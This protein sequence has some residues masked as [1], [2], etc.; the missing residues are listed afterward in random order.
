MC[1]Q[2]ISMIIR[3]KVAQLDARPAEAKVD[4]TKFLDPNLAIH[5]NEEFLAKL[6]THLDVLQKI[7]PTFNHKICKLFELMKVLAI[8]GDREWSTDFL[9][10][11]TVQLNN[12]YDKLYKRFQT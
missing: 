2:N 1:Q 7:A 11:E 4:L 8:E 6:V 5:S 12:Q 9:T 3:N 10:K